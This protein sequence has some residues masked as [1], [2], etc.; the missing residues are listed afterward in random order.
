M[1][2]KSRFFIPIVYIITSVCFIS[3][4]QEAGSFTDARDGKVYKTVKIDNQEW[5]GENLAFKTES[6]CWAYDDVKDYAATYGY[7]Y[8]WEAASKA[9]PSGWRLSSMQDWWYLSTYLGG[10]DQAGG[11]LKAT[12]TGSWK[13][14]NARATNSSGFTALAGGQSGDK[15]MEYLGSAAFF[16][17]NADDDDAISWCAALSSTDGELSFLQTE[18]KNGYSVR[19]IKISDKLEKAFDFW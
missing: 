8:S 5:M 6:G 16:W 18:K 19:C 11:K 13:S 7:L 4:G 1:K 12:G 10:D 3:Y 17:T 2:K 15:N 14:P 9:C